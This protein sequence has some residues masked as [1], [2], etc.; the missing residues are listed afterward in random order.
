MGAL[1]VAV[2]VEGGNWVG[3]MPVLAVKPVK[4]LESREFV[5]TMRL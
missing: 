4:V 1:V 3:A 5:A 2:P